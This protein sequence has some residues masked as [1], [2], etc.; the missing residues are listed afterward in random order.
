LERRYQPIAPWHKDGRYSIPN[1]DKLDRRPSA[2]DHSTEIPGDTEIIC[3]AGSFVRSQSI[4]G[5]IELIAGQQ[6]D[7]MNKAS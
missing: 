2:A 7:H 4:A 1:S 6:T 5:D 3:V